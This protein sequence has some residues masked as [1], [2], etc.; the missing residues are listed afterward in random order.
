MRLRYEVEELKKHGRRKDIRNQIREVSE[1]PPPS[2]PQP[3]VIQIKAL[4]H[5][6]AALLNRRRQERKAQRQHEQQ[7]DLPGHADVEGVAAEDRAMT[8]PLFLKDV[9]HHD[10]QRRKERHRC[11]QQGEHTEPGKKRPRILKLIDEREKL[12]ALI[13]RRHVLTHEPSDVVERI[14]ILQNPPEDPAGDTRR[15]NHDGDDRDEHFEG[16][17]LRPEED[18]LLK[19]V[20]VYAAHVIGDAFPEPPPVCS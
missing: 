9:P 17:R 8:M 4:R 16:D 13:E 18:V 1:G 11:E 2:L 20:A 19:Q 15:E 6:Q 3:H 10:A 14:W 12:I 5:L 7:A